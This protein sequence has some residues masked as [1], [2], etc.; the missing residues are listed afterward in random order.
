MQNSEYYI[1]DPSAMS[2]PDLYP[3]LRSCV[4]KSIPEHLRRGT[5]CDETDEIVDIAAH[6][7][8]L[9]LDRARREGR[10]LSLSDLDVLASSIVKEVQRERRHQRALIKHFVRVLKQNPGV[11]QNWIAAF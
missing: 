10:T 3:I 6:L 8:W 1:V 9:R 7:A 4:S 2:P 11:M 5:R